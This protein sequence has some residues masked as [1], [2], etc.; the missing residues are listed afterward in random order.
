[1]RTSLACFRRSLNSGQ[2]R[3]ELKMIPAWSTGK[4]A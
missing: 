4:A 1:M 2:A 3:I